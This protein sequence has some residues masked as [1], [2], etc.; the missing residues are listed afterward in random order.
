[1]NGKI[2]SFLFLTL[3]VPLLS[4]PV[5]LIHEEDY[6]WAQI[7]KD[8]GYSRFPTFIDTG[9]VFIIV[10]RTD[11]LYGEGGGIDPF[12]LIIGRE[13]TFFVFFPSKCV[14]G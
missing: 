13:P 8:H 3:Q 6:V 7:A 9:L 1:M 4:F 12:I 11:S 5:L 10:D 2:K 14:I